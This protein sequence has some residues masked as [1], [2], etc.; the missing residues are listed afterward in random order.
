MRK[1][2]HIRPALRKKID[3]EFLRE[4]HRTSWADRRTEL[5]LAIRRATSPA[6]RKAFQAQLREHYQHENDL[7]A[8]RNELRARRADRANL[9]PSRA[10]GW[11]HY[12]REH[13]ATLRAWW[14]AHRAP[15]LSEQRTTWGDLW[16][17]LRL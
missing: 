17:A 11:R 6:E 16:R 12:V 4:I 14:C 10:S 1:P 3:R 8:M 15:K 2:N 5:L 7:G 9:P 13:F